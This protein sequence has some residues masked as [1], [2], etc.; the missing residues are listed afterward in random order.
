M[1]SKPRVDL[2]LIPG[3]LCDHRLWSSQ[4]QALAEFARGETPDLTA[5]ESIDAMAEALLSA[6]PEHFAL[7]GF[8]IG[9]CVKLEVIARA[10]QRVRQLAL[11][12]TSAAGLLPGVRQNYLQ[13]ITLL[14]AAGLARYLADAFPR[15]M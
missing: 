3:L 12:S 10:P 7:A 1:T 11:L 9:G 5:C 13:S 14:Q 2:L 8:S 4:T 15:Y 6:A